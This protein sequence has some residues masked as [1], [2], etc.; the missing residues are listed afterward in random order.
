M[1]A[2]ADI[3]EEDL[4]SRRE[5][6]D[7]LESFLS[8][9]VSKR[10][11]DGQTASYVINIDADWGEGKS[12]FLERF[13]RQLKAR[14]HV[15][16]N[17][18]AWRDDHTDDPFVAVLSAIDEAIKPLI[19]E[20]VTVRDRW[21]KVKES[22][23]PTMG[24]VFAG[25]TRATVK[26]YLDSEIDDLFA[27]G[28]SSSV[29]EGLAA[30]AK[31]GIRQAFALSKATDAMIS[32]FNQQR[33]SI[34]QFRERMGHVV[35]CISQ[36]KLLFVLIDELDR[37][38]PSYAIALLE[39]IKHLFDA[40]GV[41]FV[42]ATNSSQLQHSIVGAYGPNFEG[43]RYL[44]RFFDITYDLQAPDRSNFIEFVFKE[45]NSRSLNCPVE[46]I[47]E[48]LRVAVGSYNLNLRETQKLSETIE[49]VLDGWVHQI[50]PE[51][52]FLVPLAIQLIRTGRVNV[53]NL[54]AEI[55]KNFS[56]SRARRSEFGNV[57]R[58]TDSFSVK[59]ALGEIIK[60]SE[61]LDYAIEKSS[62]SSR[63]WQARYISNAFSREYNGVPI[64]Q[65]S[66]SIQSRL[67]SLV[68]YAGR[69]SSTDEH[70]G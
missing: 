2:N 35:D 25:A 69:F 6:A 57:I 49:Y 54:V 24:R 38:R 39:R 20:N 19:P 31:E 58:G 46:D 22:A 66:P 43:F 55:P 44:Q 56:F 40:N 27:D 28:E 45:I 51:I 64:K 65:G 13:S 10:R 11:K 62:G 3:W 23:L 21:K 9:Q 68:A 36:E 60:M 53:E 33:S 16:A 70:D 67:P 26:R 5:E 50:D 52:V 32:K 12:F 41:V 29:D 8:K 7:Y 18:N 15:V 48:F 47:M 14:G 61:S 37:C 4:L 59:S 30:G 42:F 34:D 17:V 63:D 1:S